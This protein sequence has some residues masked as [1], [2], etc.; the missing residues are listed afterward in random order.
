MIGVGALPVLAHER[1]EIL[2]RASRPLDETFE[3]L[4]EL[5]ALVGVTDFG[6]D[7]LIRRCEHRLELVLELDYRAARRRVDEVGV[8]LGRA[9]QRE[10]RREIKAGKA[11]ERLLDPRQVQ[12]RASG[13]F[14]RFDAARHLPHRGDREADSRQRL[15]VKAG[16]DHG[17]IVSRP[18][19]RGQPF[20]SV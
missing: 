7:L 11:W 14:E 17:L 20:S 6:H 13:V 19:K 9:L 10:Q 3:H 4:R 8:V 16:F 2:D 1:R 12:R 18:V 5:L 15:S